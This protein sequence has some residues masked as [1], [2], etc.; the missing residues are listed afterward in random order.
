MKTL[1]ALPQSTGKLHPVRATKKEN[2]RFISF[3]A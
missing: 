2:I 1:L 3:Y